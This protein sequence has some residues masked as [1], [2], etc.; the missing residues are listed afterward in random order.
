MG[1]LTMPLAVLQA[2]VRN[3]G[4][5]QNRDSARGAA[6]ATFPHLDARTRRRVL[7]DWQ[8]YEPVRKVTQEEREQMMKAIGIVVEKS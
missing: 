3:M 1:W 5:L 7:G 6:V 8:G 4:P 2:Y